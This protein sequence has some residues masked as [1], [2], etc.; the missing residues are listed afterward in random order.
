MTSLVRDF[1]DLPDDISPDAF[2]QRVDQT[3]A[4][5]LRQYVLPQAVKRRLSDQLRAVGGRLSQGKDIGRF[6]Y[7]TFG[8]G[9]SHLLQVMGKM[10]ERD[11]LVYEVGDAGL[12][13]LRQEHPWLDGQKRL[14]VR[15]NMMGKRSLL[16]AL[17]AAYQAALPVGSAPVQLSN[18]ERIF[19]LIQQDAER[20]GGKAELVKQLRT[21][22]IVPSEALFD[23]KVNGPIEGR[24]EFAAQLLQ[25]RNHG[26][27]P[28]AA[29]A[30]SMWLP[31]GAGFDAIAR[32][33]KSQG[34][35]AICW[36]IDE[37]VI[38]I[39]GKKQADYAAQINDLSSLV[40]H[41]GKAA[42]PLPFFVALAV[43]TDITETCPEDMSESGFRQHL[44][45]IQDRFQ[46]PLLLEDTDLYEVCERR[47]LRRKDGVEKEW[48]EAVDGVM[49]RHREALQTLQADTSA[50]QVRGLYPFHPALLRVLTDVT[51]AF[52]RSRTGV[53]LLYAL[54]ADYCGTLEVGQ[55]VPVGTL[56][57]AIFTAEN[58]IQ[59]RNR[60]KSTFA[61][62][63]VQS[64]EAFDRIR[65]ALQRLSGTTDSCPFD[66]TW[67]CSRC[68]RAHDDD[69]HKRCFQLNQ[70]VK[71][72]LLAQQSHKEFFAD[73][74][75]LSQAITVRNL[76]RLNL[77]D[78][79]TRNE[80]AG[81]ARLTKLLKDVS[82][83][84]TELAVSGDGAEA[85][86]AVDTEGIDVA[87]II[88]QAETRVH[89]PD[90]F[91]LCRRLVDDE[92][93]LKLGHSTE[94]TARILWRGTRR[95]GKVRFCNVR[96]LQYAGGRN[97]FDAGKDDFLILVDYPFDEDRSKDRQDDRDRLDTVRGRGRQWT[98]AWL[99]SHFD[100]AEY[101]ALT[102]AAAIE[103]VRADPREYLSRLALSKQ[104]AALT[105]LERI[106]T[107]M[108]E[109]LRDAIL[110]RYFEEG[111]LEPLQDG[112]TLDLTHADRRN[113][114]G[115][116]A[117]RLLEVRYPQHPP[118]PRLVSG[119]DIDTVLAWVI[120]AGKTGKP[121]DLK[122]S[123]LD[124]AR[125][126]AEPLDLIWPGASSITAR[127]DG[128]Y[129]RQVLDW[130]KDR[131][132][133]QASELRSKLQQEGREGFGLTDDVAN[134]FLFYLMQVR[135]YEAVNARGVGL[136]IE[137]ASKLPPQFILR[138]DDVVSS[139]EWDTARNAGKALFGLS[140]RKELPSSP[141]QAKLARDAVQA[142][143][144]VQK[145]LE[146][147]RSKLT[148]VCRWL[149]A[150]VGDSK[151]LT[152]AEVVASALTDLLSATSNSEKV[153]KLG[154]LLPTD[155]VAQKERVGCTTGAAGDHQA[156][157]EMAGK[158]N[159]VTVVE[160]HGTTEEQ[161][162]LRALRRLVLDPASIGLAKDWPRIKKQLDES[163]RAVMK[164]IGP[165]K[166]PPGTKRVAKGPV[167][168][169]RTDIAHEAARLAEEALA[170]IGEGEGLRVTVV[171]ERRS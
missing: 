17:Y 137:F 73:G 93:G 3:T 90:R 109:R 65:P 45:F 145:Q 34:Y 119:R 74:R 125:A 63:L 6:V 35:E 168:V 170:D 164:R 132:E 108:T 68:L 158:Q 91:K 36:L 52:S 127:E 97:E 37:L 18:H 84:A 57:D 19:A 146:G 94:T 106:Q 66:P 167:P 14:V 51:Q 159:E 101:K 111:S 64:G 50:E 38:W 86:V 5:T 100:D 161:Q 44:G 116:I 135:D 78:I 67:G 110:K 160:T 76:I 151:R 26:D 120:E 23:K 60:E 141:E 153:R 27:D 147:L 105:K 156:A 136:T 157:I 117:K 99:P 139:V 12:R 144:G 103:L 24:L 32:H 126:I 1:L 89:H 155:P 115:A 130:T 39:R 30:E 16:G 53:Q 48:G 69:A 13:E 129:L 9:K 124:L 81:A 150:P 33:A 54:L 41:D 49:T 138:K 15:V 29:D 112:A 21:D 118:F 11:E 113:T 122:K 134:L 58:R 92:L 10:L 82:A 80:R 70:V 131:R 114:V 62:L 98:A 8:S 22:G 104:Q 25:W 28:L 143:V 96:T 142:A 61:R 4:D 43:Q 56:F 20:M 162:P 47:V 163:F 169:Q 121:I 148:Q 87:D 59:L 107:T 40:D 79:R 31:A 83:D 165:K 2:I 71:T 152:E 95:K 133:F 166:P 88:Q 171:V 55:L 123:E 154:G 128:R 75:R 102:T 42:R 72:T 77:A 149:T 46:P 7:G 85:R 140:K